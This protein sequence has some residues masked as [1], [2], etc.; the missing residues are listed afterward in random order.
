MKAKL[1]FTNVGLEGEFPLGT[2]ILEAAEELGAPEGSHCAGVCACSKCHVY[3]EQ[4]EEHLSVM[5]E[6]EQDMLELAAEE[7]EDKSLRGCQALMSSAGLICVRISEESF[8]QYLESAAGADRDRAMALWT[9]A[10]RR[11]E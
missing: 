3:V 4:G 1:R 8:S 5:Q 9:S 10:Q 11:Q 6:D 2:S 7:L